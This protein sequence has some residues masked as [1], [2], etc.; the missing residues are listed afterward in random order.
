MKLDTFYELTLEFYT[1]FKYIDDG[2]YMFSCRCFGREFHMYYDFFS[3]VFEFP[4]GG[5]TLP[6]KDFDT[7]VF[8]RKIIEDNSFH[9]RER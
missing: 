9:E 2:T 5:I 4:K 7:L 8:W 3:Y 1:T 6:P